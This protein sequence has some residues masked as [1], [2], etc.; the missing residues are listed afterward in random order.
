MNIYVDLTDLSD[1]LPLAALPIS[2]RAYDEIVLIDSALREARKHACTWRSW[3]ERM[4]RQM[5]R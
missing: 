2:C 5:S 4:E 3:C 1:S